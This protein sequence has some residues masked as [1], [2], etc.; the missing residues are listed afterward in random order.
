MIDILVAHKAELID[1]VLALI[2]VASVV[3]AGTKT[4]APSTWLGKVYKVVEWAALTFG[5]AKE[6]GEPVKEKVEVK[7]AVG[8]TEK[9]G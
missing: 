8:T 7:E 5:R 4:P 1:A 6:T 3:V 2:V 9:V